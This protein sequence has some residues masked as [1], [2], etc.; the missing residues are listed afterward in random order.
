MLP[1]SSHDTSEWGFLKLANGLLRFA[2]ADSRR[3]F[4]TDGTD[5]LF[6]QKF[7]AVRQADA[8]PRNHLSSSK[9]CLSCDE[10]AGWYATRTTGFE[11][12]SNT[13]CAYSGD[14][15]SSSRA[16]V[17]S[18]KCFSTAARMTASKLVLWSLA[19]S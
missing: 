8:T 7:V 1:V 9:C 14:R 18:F 5:G 11:V 13:E 15:F 16:T 3:Y 2:V 4:S 6:A 10:I 19:S 12:R 17:T